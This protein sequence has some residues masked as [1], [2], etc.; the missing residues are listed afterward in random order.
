MNTDKQTKPPVAIPLETKM[1]LK[2]E[3]GGI[4]LMLFIACSGL[5]LA[6]LQTPILQKMD[7]MDLFSTLT[8]MASLGL[9][10]MTP[11][12]GKLGDMF[13]RRN[14]ILVSGLL[15]LLCNIAL[16]FATNKIVFLVLRFLLGA[17]QGA[18]TSAPF[19]ILNEINERNAVP[20]KM[21]ILISAI[22][23]G[24][25]LGSVIAG[26]F[27]DHNLLAAAI[28]FPTIFL[29]LALLLIGKN[30]PNHKA[31]SLTTIDWPGVLTLTIFMSAFLLTLNYGT[32]LSWMNPLILAG[33]ATAIL[34][35]FILVQVENK[36]E[37]PI[38]PMRLF[39]NKRYTILLLIGFISYIY[40]TTINTY[41]PLATLKVMGQSATLTGTLQ[42]PRVL[43]TIILPAILGAWVGKKKQ[44][45]GIAMIITL[46]LLTVAFLPLSFTTPT[47]SIFVYFAMIALTGIA[48]SFRAVSV[49]P[50][51]QQCLEPSDIGIGTSLVTFFNSTAAPFS[52]ALFGVILDINGENLNRGVNSVFFTTA[53][54][55]FIGLLLVLFF[56]YRPGKEQS[57]QT[58]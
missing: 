54:L 9:S 36:A 33:F 10:I 41:C 43:L 56:I 19:I 45:F 4:F 51:A 5:S 53:V 6:M 49:T 23:A 31:S 17:C 18:F 30:L 55:S 7:A 26:I 8:I 58:D 44:H 25:F 29:L 15:A 50:S 40:Q 24:G 3:L 27:V 20:K 47:T 14:L 2:V 12:G 39:H 42:L 52:G 28:L 13:G 46:A 57:Q 48:D 1:R 16:A 37:N 22:T 21:G 35:A 32:R 38:I 34:S 11:I